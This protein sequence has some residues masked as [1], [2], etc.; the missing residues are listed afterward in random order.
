MNDSDAV[1]LGEATSVARFESMTTD[2]FTKGIHRALHQILLEE[3]VVKLSSDTVVSYN[4][5]KLHQ[6]MTN[7]V[8][9]MALLSHYDRKNKAATAAASKESSTTQ[10][11]EVTPLEITLDAE[12]IIFMV[13]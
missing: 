9:W 4:V 3:C 2:A 12:Y 7:E 10:T 11:T 8:D 13:A 6:V 5:E 1:K